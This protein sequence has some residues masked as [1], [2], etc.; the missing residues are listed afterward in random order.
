MKR[1]YRTII[2]LIG[3]I[4]FLIITPSSRTQTD[5]LPNQ[6][7]KT[8]LQPIIKGILAAWDK[9][10]V[11][12]LGEDHAS[13]NDSD[14]RITLVEHPDFIKKVSV[15]MVE[16]ANNVH[17]DLLDRFA[18]DGEDIPHEQLRQ[19]WAGM[20]STPLWDLPTY[21]LFLRAIRKI[22][23]GVVK[24]RRIRILAGDDFRERNRGKVIRE[25]VAREILDKHLK[26]LTI[27]GAGHCECRAMGFPGELEDKYPKRIWSAFNFYDV[28]AGRQTFGLSDE[29]ALIPVTGTDKAKLPI[30]KMFSLG[31]YNDPATLADITNAIVYYGNIKD[32]KVSAQ[33]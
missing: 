20:S 18:L 30:G 7:I 4:G 9:F 19:A 17:Q 11:V 1:S 6:A 24:E 33:R 3:L 16:F 5:V 27:Y 13:K 28:D 10:D 8:R 21:E 22:N 2:I 31:R 23:L 14:L 32:V 25:L 29:P 15:V 26:A 12:C